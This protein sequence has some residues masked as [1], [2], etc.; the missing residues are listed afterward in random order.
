MA[1]TPSRFTKKFILKEIKFNLR[2]FFIFSHGEIRKFKVDK[3][4]TYRCNHEI[5]TAYISMVN[6]ASSFG[7]MGMVISKLLFCCIIY[8]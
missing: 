7:S 6:E 4:K 2:G 1:N 5:I 8:W 3:P